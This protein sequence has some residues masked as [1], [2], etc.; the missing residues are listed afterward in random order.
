MA[1]YDVKIDGSDNLYVTGRN[2]QIDTLNALPYNSLTFIA[3]FNPV[4]K[5][6]WSTYFGGT[7]VTQHDYIRDML[8]LD[9]TFYITGET[10]TINFPTIQPTGSI[11]YQDSLS[12]S[13]DA[14]I[15]K[16]VNNT[17]V[18]STYFGGDSAD[19]ASGIC[20]DINNNYYISGITFSSDFPVLDS[21]LP[22][23]YE[24]SNQGNAQSPL[25]FGYDG[26]AFLAKFNDQDQ[27]Q[28]TS[29]YGGV[30]GDGFSDVGADSQGNIFF[31]GTTANTS[32]PFATPNL[33]NAFIRN[34]LLGLQDGVIVSFN[35]NMDMQ[36]TTY[37]GGF[38]TSYNYDWITDL[39]ITGNDKLYIVG[40]TNS[41]TDFSWVVSPNPIAH[42]DST[43][44]GS[45]AFL[46]K[47]DVSIITTGIDDTE[48]KT[49]DIIV[50]PNP[51]TNTIYIDSNEQTEFYTIYNLT[52]QQVKSGI[53][54][55]GINIS[56]LSKGMYILKIDNKS[57]RKS[58]KIIKN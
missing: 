56:K 48:S 25:N 32:I 45:D 41:S 44:I 16:F 53:Y 10:E 11:Y 28:H 37:Y 17:P 55:D 12:G 54:N 30:D 36:W 1:S 42:M 22:A 19:A 2:V 50:Y 4:H 58:V 7:G 33:Q 49:N 43:N 47:F 9:N 38:Y 3:Q 24:G 27:Q 52:G 20:K 40:K 15:S 34:N 35:S 6:I 5:L 31:T 29:Y 39:E 23:Y 8:I 18:W 51:A 46:A 21:G 13:S 14:F 57:F 26:D